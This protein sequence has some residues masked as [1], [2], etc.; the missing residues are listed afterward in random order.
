MLGLKKNF[1]AD[2]VAYDQIIIELKALDKLTAQA[3]AQ[4]IN[5]LKA[6]K[7]RVG[8]L[9]NFGGSSLQWK[10]VVL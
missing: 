8:L 9:M 10:R 6:S 1:T 5:Y 4:V 3:E 7:M 2:L